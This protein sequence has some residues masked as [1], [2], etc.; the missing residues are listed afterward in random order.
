MELPDFVKLC[1]CAGCHKEL[2]GDSMWGWYEEQ[3]TEDKK[4]LPQFVETRVNGRPY[5]KW[6]LT[7]FSEKD[8][9]GAA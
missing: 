3:P 6:C 5:C 9:E 1:N 8:R 2:L 7:K 4:R